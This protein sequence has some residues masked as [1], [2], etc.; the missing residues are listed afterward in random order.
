MRKL[1][2]T[3]RFAKAFLKFARRNPPL[4]QKIENT[5]TQ[6]ADDAFAANLGTHKLE[7]KLSGTL[8]CSCGYDC[9]ILFKFDRDEET[10]EEVILLLDVG[11]HDEVY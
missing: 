3:S 6:L 2:S 5:L 9:R 4:Q 11:T 7:G 10:D 8:A 1:V